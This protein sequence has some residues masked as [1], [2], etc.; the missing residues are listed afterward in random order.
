MS[1]RVVIDGEE[2]DLESREGFELL[3]Q[4]WLRSGWSTKYVY[5]F[6]WLGRPIIQLPEDM[7][8]I[9]EVIWQVRPDLLIECG[10]AHGGSLV[11]YAS[12]FRSMGKGRV[13]G[14]D[15]E[16]R[17]HNRSALEGHPL[18][19]L[20]TLIEG[21]SVDPAIVALAREEARNAES[22]MV[23]LDS[24]HSRGHVL[25]ELRAYAELVTPGSYIVA[26]DG[27]MQDLVGA[28]RSAGDWG[29]NNPQS[30]VRDFLEE[31][32]AFELVEPRWLF[33]EGAVRSR[34]TYWPNAFL[35]R[36]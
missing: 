21:S 5:S 7:F 1:D 20:V 2:I 22:V 15:L 35:R 10:I 29:T 9:Q 16:I 32:S 26:C 3:S 25:A 36:R 19:D 4:L 8:R 14:V 17:S 24:K 27:I 12:L 31:N 30:A 23:V 28:P 34:V 33:N 11:F 13:V 6:T 18:F